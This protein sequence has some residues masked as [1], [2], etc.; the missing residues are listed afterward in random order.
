M[1]SDADEGSDS[2]IKQR[3]CCHS[4]TVTLNEIQLMLLLDPFN[5]LLF[6]TTWVCQYQKGKNSLDLNKARDDE[7]L[8]RVK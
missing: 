1:L 4:I 5:S 2:E 8:G 3:S 7:V 6:R